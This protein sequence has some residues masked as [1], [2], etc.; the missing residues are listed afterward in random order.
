MQSEQSDDRVKAALSALRSQIGMYRY[1]VSGTLERARNTL[2]SGSGPGQTRATLGDFASGR[3]DPERFAMISSGSGPLDIVDFAVVQ[4]AIEVLES[5]LSPGDDAFVVDI[6]HGGSPGKAIRERLA[7]LGSAFGAGVIVELVRRHLYELAKQG[8][9]SEG[10][11]FESWTTGERKLAPPLVVRLDGR[12]LDPFELAPLMDG[13]MR[14]VLVVDGPCAP[15]PLARLISPGVFVAQTGNLKVLDKLADFDGPAVVAIMN[16]PEARF[17]HDP[18]GGAAMWQRI[19]VERM[20]DAL[21][22]KSLGSRSAWQQRDDFSHLKALVEPPSLRAIPAG[23]LAATA[24]GGI[25]DPVERLTA[26]LV[27]QTRRDGIA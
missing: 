22:R 11:P 2:A 17:V 10:H 14:L 20:P 13:Y 25:S 7:T 16:G 15:A 9:P 21:P 19:R 26:W 27:D 1:V 5:V 3:I 24:D 18:R 6:D 12:D 4:R 8:L 23:S